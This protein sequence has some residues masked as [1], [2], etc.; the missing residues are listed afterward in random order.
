MPSDVNK[1]VSISLKA[2]L[3]QLEA[4]L[5]KLPSMTEREAR[6]MV[7][8]LSKELKKS[9]KAAK[10]AARANKKQLEAMR[11]QAKKTKDEF[12]QMGKNIGLSVAAAGVA[13]LAFTQQIADLSN[14]LVD[15]STKT[16]LSVETLQG[17]RLAAE[18]AGLTFG[19]LEQGLLKLPKQMLK[20]QQ[21]SKKQSE[22]FK[23][24]GV[25]VVEYRDG[26]EQLRNA[27]DVLNELFESLRNVSTQEEKAALA[28]ELFGQQAG[29]KLIQS[30]ALDNLESFV[31]LSK[32]FGVSTGP[33]M[34]NA[35]AD[36][37]RVSAAAM[38]TA[39]GEVQRLLD[40]FTG[41]AEGGGMSAAV[42]LVTESFLFL[43]TVVQDTFEG[44]RAT[45]S[46]SGSMISAGFMALAG[47][48]EEAFK[49]LKEEAN[50]AAESTDNMFDTFE[51]GTQRVNRFRSEVAKTLSAPTPTGGGGGDGDG[52]TPEQKEQ[53]IAQETAK[54]MSEIKK[55]SLQLEKDL[56]KATLDRLEGDEKLSEQIKQRVAEI[57]AE[58]KKNDEM[59]QSLINKRNALGE[60]M[61]TEEE[62]SELSAQTT[63][64]EKQLRQEIADLSKKLLEEGLNAEIEAGLADLENDTKITEAKI[65]NRKRLDAIDEKRRA[66]ELAAN[67]MLLSSISQSAD[68]A[69]NIASE[70]FAKNKGLI[71]TLFNVKKAATLAEIAMS[72][73]A[74]FQAAFTQYG[75]FAPVAQAAIIASGIAQAAVV[76]SQAPPKLHMGGIVRANPDEQTRTLLTGEAVLDRATVRRIGEDGVNRLQ[77][78]GSSEPIVVVTNPYK[79]F[80]RFMRDRK[81]VG[82]EKKSGRNGY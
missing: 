23:R 33:E 4:G 67:Q 36:F 51:R 32:E 73:A 24:L 70:S 5:S 49:I 14:E 52:E 7:R 76:A 64:R 3:S 44:I 54:A 82:A 11:R 9:E 37:Q 6:A 45:V 50:K 8:G 30:G 41:A 66:Q 28:A 25:D 61:L 81:R 27:D 55:F 78:G 58:I 72:T 21:G 12:R 38:E 74:A 19:E 57:E 53:K 80:D 18:G 68:A 65:E 10:D 60:Y 39:T 2:N 22:I 31:S 1:S 71:L 56:K 69:F 29:P 63:E 40:T 77:S 16:G 75:V 79:H 26:L 47:N 46:F 13:V 62:S 17:L 15:S 48:G 35:M 59:T 42:M 34:R 43:S 20:V